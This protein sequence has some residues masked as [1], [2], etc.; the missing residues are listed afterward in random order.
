MMTK[1]MK[2][3]NTQIKNMKISLENM[4]FKSKQNK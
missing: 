1:D 4:T 2:K 3:T